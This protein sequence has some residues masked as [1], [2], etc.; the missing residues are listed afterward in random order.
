M[1]KTKAHQNQT[2]ENQ[3]WMGKKTLK[4]SQRKKGTLP[5][6]EKRWGWE[7][8]SHRKCCKQEDSGAMSLKYW[9]KNYYQSKIL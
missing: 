6:E 8:I 5:T 9:E 1:K 3:R 7:Q 4:N 2:A